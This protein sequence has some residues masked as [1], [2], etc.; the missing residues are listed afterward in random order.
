MLR[1][2]I[3]ALLIIAL[4]FSISTLIDEGIMGSFVF[5][6]TISIGNIIEGVLVAALVIVTSYYAITTRKTLAAVNRSTEVSV[7]PHI[8]CSMAI[9]GVDTLFLKVSNVGVGSA[10][11]VNLKY[12][13]ESIENSDRDWVSST[14]LPKDAY[15]FYIKRKDDDKLIGLSY[16]SRN[17]TTIKVSG[18]YTDI[19]EIPYTIDESIDVTDISKKLLSSQQMIRTDDMEEINHSLKDIK[20]D[21]RFMRQDFHRLVRKHDN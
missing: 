9:I 21:L 12:E 16:C 4:A 3:I 15:T 19:L 18:S 11:N 20:D 8:K 1:E 7:K 5:D 17:Q 2:I 13:I 6:N 14:M 10:L